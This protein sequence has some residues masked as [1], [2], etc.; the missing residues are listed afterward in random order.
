MTATG[1]A[2]DQNSVVVTIRKTA[3]S[4]ATI[5]SQRYGTNLI[6]E[7]RDYLHFADRSDVGPPWVA[8]MKLVGPCS[9]TTD[10]Q[11]YN[12]TSNFTVFDFI[13]GLPFHYL[14]TAGHCFAYEST[15]TNGSGVPIGPVLQRFF[16]EGSNSDFEII[17][18]DPGTQS[19]NVIT[20]DPSQYP[21]VGYETTEALNEGVCKS[22]ITTGETCGWTIT[23]IHATET[24]CLDIPCT[25]TI[26]LVDQIEATNPGSSSVDLGDSGGPVYHYDS[27]PNIWATGVVS[28]KN[29]LG[30]LMV[31]TFFYNALLNEGGYLCTSG[32]C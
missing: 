8:G 5:L 1:I 7:E 31:Y 22:G 3:P 17:L 21:V 13:Q 16:Y 6:I 18:E 10:C 12:C 24:L 15:V 29:G 2:P 19:P 28:A 25:Q 32:V 23:K 26:D 27:V 14:A 9:G 30:N 4:T 20:T 11:L